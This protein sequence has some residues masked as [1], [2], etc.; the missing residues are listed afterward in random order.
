MLKKFRLSL[1]A[2]SLFSTIGF[3]SAAVAQRSPSYVCYFI[4]NQG[5]VI[6]LESLCAEDDQPSDGSPGSSAGGGSTGNGATAGGQANGEGLLTIQDAELSAA[7]VTGFVVNQTNQPIAVDDLV[8]A[9]VDENGATVLQDTINLQNDVV[10]PGE[11]VQFIDEFTSRDRNSLSQYNADGLQIALRTD[12][13][14]SIAILEQDGTNATTGETIDGDALNPGLDQDLGGDGI[15]QTDDLDAT[16][17]FETE[18][19]LDSTFDADEET[20][21]DTVIDPNVP[22]FE[23]QDISDEQDL[24]GTNDIDSLETLDSSGE[25]FGEFDNN[26]P[27]DPN[28]DNSLEDADGLNDPNGLG[29]NDETESLDGVDEL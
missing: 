15:S 19:D 7:G 23:E 17:D 25:D 4:N 13:N 18:P 6:N 5:E 22:E 1:L 20:D 21:L 14:S 3:S 24:D 11:P 28:D 2:A 12:E 16:S 26:E 9:L 10:L 27:I 8:Y 29:I